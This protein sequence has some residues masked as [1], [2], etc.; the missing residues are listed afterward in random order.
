MKI[1]YYNTLN[2][3]SGFCRNGFIIFERKMNVAVKD[4]N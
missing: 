2:I 1:S 3:V 4:K